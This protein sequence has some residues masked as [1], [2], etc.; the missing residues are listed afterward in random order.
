MKNPFNPKVP[1]NTEDP[2][3]KMADQVMQ[4]AQ[5]SIEND[6]IKALPY[7]E[8]DFVKSSQAMNPKR[9]PDTVQE[10]LTNLVKKVDKNPASPVVSHLD[11][12]LAQGIPLY[13]CRFQQSVPP[14]VN[15]EPVAEFNLEAK[16][17]KYVVERMVY[18][19]HGVIFSAFGETNIVPL[20]NVM[21]VRT[22]KG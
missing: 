2:A 10:L 13:Y 12:W 8:E 6:L 4:S 19:P 16:H 22:I 21:Y 14:A 20:A 9:T 7:A 3:K 11:E 5:N 15:K 18:T 1:K 17:H